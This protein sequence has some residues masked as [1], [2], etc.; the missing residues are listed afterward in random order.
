MWLCE[1]LCVVCVVCKA[2]ESESG[3]ERWPADATRC[4]G[5]QVGEK[6]MQ[7]NF[8]DTTDAEENDEL[9]LESPERLETVTK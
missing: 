9:L 4:C 7:C 2:F 5:K 3:A 6:R 1:R 8:D